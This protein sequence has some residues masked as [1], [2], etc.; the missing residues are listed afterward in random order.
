M[1][2]CKALNLYSRQNVCHCS[3]SRQQSS[4]FQ[5]VKCNNVKVYLSAIMWRYT[6]HSLLT[7]ALSIRKRKHRDP[8]KMLMCQKSK[9]KWCMKTMIGVSMLPCDYIYIYILYI[10]NISVTSVL[11]LHVDIYEC[12]TRFLNPFLA[13]RYWVSLWGHRGGAGAGVWACTCLARGH[14]FS[15]YYSNAGG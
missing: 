7:H 4:R 10:Y 14:C 15:V 1:I 12:F 5:S 6:V 3:S 13:D 9:R 8:R 2:K 11:W